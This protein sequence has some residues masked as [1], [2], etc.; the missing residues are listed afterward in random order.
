MISRRPRLP[1]NGAR[2]GVRLCAKHQSQ[3]VAAWRTFELKCDPGLLRLV[4]LR[5]T[6]SRSIRFE[7]SLAPRRFFL[8]APAFLASAAPCS[9][10]NAERHPHSAWRPPSPIRLAALPRRRSRWEREGVKVD[11][12]KR[13]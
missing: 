6:Q 1:M 10:T 11:V 8:E 9:E 13:K 4:P 2:S 5:R 7:R 12:G 3:Q